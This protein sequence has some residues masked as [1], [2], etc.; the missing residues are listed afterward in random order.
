MQWSKA[1]GSDQVA[2]TSAEVE[3][4]HTLTK[5][6][7]PAP[8]EGDKSVAQQNEPPHVEGKLSSHAAP[9]NDDGG[10]GKLPEAIDMQEKGQSEQ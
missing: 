6:V 10:E 4:H 7:T 1:N 3:D 2:A 9:G 8:E 5:E